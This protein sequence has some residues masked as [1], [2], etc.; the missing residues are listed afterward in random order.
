MP[1]FITHRKKLVSAIYRLTQLLEI[2]AFRSHLL[3][4]CPHFSLA[5][6]RLFKFLRSVRAIEHSRKDEVS[7]HDWCVGQLMANLSR[8]CTVHRIFRVN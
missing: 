6:F 5:L 1:C 4:L 8:V 7:A 3:Q 2:N